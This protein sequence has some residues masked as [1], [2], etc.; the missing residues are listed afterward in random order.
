MSDAVDEGDLR[1][2]VLRLRR[3]LVEIA[4]WSDDPGS[5]YLARYALSGGDDPE[6]LPGPYDEGR[7][8]L[9]AWTPPDES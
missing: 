5:K 3:F 2:E 4:Q 9:D 6:T 7:A 8:A 1:A